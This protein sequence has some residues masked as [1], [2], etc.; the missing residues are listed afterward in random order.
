MSVKLLDNAFKAL[1]L[2]KCT[3]H[4]WCDSKVVLPWILNPNL[5][6]QKFIARRIE[7]IHRFS[8]LNNW[9]Y[10]ATDANPADIATRPLTKSS[11]TRTEFW[12]KGPKF[13]NQ[14]NFEQAEV[15]KI[16]A[17]RQI[18]L[19]KA[20]AETTLVHLIESAPS[21]CILNQR[22]SYLCVF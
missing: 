16:M 12:L 2:S 13:L 20:H 4:F 7:I 21:W 5:R 3:K 17:I 19:A 15:S 9:K 6:L 22:T 14:P 8:S 18:H 10:C 11:Y 1:Y